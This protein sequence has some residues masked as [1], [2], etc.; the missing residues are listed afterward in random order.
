MSLE[1]TRKEAKKQN[2]FVKTISY[3]HLSVICKER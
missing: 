3:K 2:K 1:E